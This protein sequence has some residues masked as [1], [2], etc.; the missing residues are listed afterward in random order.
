[1]SF[2]IIGTGHYVPEHVVTNDDLAKMVDTNDEWIVQRV[3][4]SERR[5]SVCE[6][7]SE[8]GYKAASAALE[9]A[10]VSPSEID[11][12]IACTISTEN[13]S[14]SLSCSIQEKLGIGCV[15]YDI[16]AACSSFLFALEAAAGHFARKRCKKALVVGAER[17]SGLVDWTD[18]ST[19]VI[20]GDGAGAAVL[21][22]GDGYIDSLFNVKG[23]SDV[24]K[25]PA[26]GANSPFFKGE[27][28]KPA[29][30]MEGQETF[31]F[32][33]NAICKDIKAIL[34]KNNLTVD[35]IAYIVPHQANLRIIDFAA[36]KLGIPRERFA[37]NI[38][39]YGN[40]SGA[41]VPMALDEINREG[42]LKDGDL[43]VMCAFGGGLAD[44]ANL[45]RWKK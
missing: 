14:P 24:I 39:K 21:E 26:Y 25:I 20:F 29:I 30:H 42:K 6:T 13:I 28:E 23:G 36:R 3:G 22:E 2:N 12:I 15:C 41:S 4:I 19:C 33:V 9:N 37:V 16:N 5:V 38:H 43:V 45:I 17:L 44:A 8:M 27:V 1:M 32:A 31:K 10:G 7:T 35:D 18:R 11:L 34:D 40:T